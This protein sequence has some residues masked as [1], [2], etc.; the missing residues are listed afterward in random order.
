MTKDYRPPAVI[1]DRDGTLAAV[2][3]APTEDRSDRAWK[4][5]NAS[6]PFDAPIPEVVGL[7]RSIRPGV[8]RIIVSG[9]AEGDHPGDRRRRFALQ[10]WLFKHSIPYDH[11]FMRVG[12]DHRLDSIAKEE[13][14]NRDILP[15]FNPVLAVD[16][17]EVVILVWKKY[18][19]YTIKVTD[20]GILPPIVG[21]VDLDVGR[22]R[23]LYPP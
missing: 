4:E 15:R 19:I 11:L 18:G 17:R 6:L 22:D 16:D 10:D 3:N 8:V 14:L 21:Q 2:H 9:R 23:L 13:I 1:F 20:P 7:L 12:G 5:Y